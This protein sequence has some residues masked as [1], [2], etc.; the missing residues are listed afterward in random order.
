MTNNHTLGRYT[1][2][3]QAANTPMSDTEMYYSSF[4]SGLCRVDFVLLPGSGCVAL[5]L[6]LEHDGDG[7]N[8]SL[9]LVTK[10]VVTLA[11]SF[12]CHSMAAGTTIPISPL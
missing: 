11:A 4:H 9:I 5:V 8:A 10:D 3:R 2:Q 12:R 6:H 7:L 1:K